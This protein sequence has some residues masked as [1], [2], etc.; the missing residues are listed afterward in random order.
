[1]AKINAKATSDFW[2]PDS[3][4]ISRI[5]PLVP[6]KLTRM[7]TPVKLSNDSSFYYGEKRNEVVNNRSGDT[8][9]FL[10]NFV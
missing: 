5:S 1:M 6:T 2:P 10:L 9:Y 4:F 3:W 8:G 7:P